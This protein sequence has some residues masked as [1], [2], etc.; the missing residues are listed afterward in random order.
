MSLTRT[1]TAYS[2]PP[3]AGT[4]GTSTTS[5]NAAG[6]MIVSNFDG[7]GRIISTSGNTAPVT[8]TYDTVVASGS[9]AG[10]VV[11]TITTGSGSTVLTTS[12]YADGAG[13]VVKTVDI[14]GKSRNR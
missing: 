9:L 5:T 4:I 13:H 8:Y 1:I 3:P 2:P 14:T 6:Q 11:S 10:L 12:A 7:M